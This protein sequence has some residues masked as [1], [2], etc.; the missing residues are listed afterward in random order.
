MEEVLQLAV[1][2]VASL[3]F[4]VF[5]NVHGYRVL[6]NSLGASLVWAVY[7]LVH[8]MT[9]DI[10]IS[11]LTATTVIALICEGLARI[12]RTPTVLMIVPMIVPPLIPGSDLYNTFFNLIKNDME[13]FS[14]YG[15]RL[16]LEIAAINFGILLAG[17]LVKLFKYLIL[18]HIAAIRIRSRHAGDR[19]QE[20]ENRQ[21]ERR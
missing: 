16:I 13:Q 7:L 1:V 20:G 6:I 4:S 14:F 18:N 15:I 17:T 19:Q 3:G 5:F 8:G 11:F 21:H 12:T 10:F 9:E 2:F